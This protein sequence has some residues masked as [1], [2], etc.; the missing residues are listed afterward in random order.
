MALVTLGTV[1]NNA[2]NAM[3]W[4]PGALRADL[5]QIG[6]NIKD[7]AN[8]THP[9]VPGGLGFDGRVYL[10]GGRGVI[11][12]QLGDY[13]GYDNYGWPIIVSKESI[14]SGSSWAHT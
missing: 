4:R 3:I 10:P 2:L 8:P 9:I 14:A 6:A 13:I 1:A 11:M 5:A 7:Q 12:L